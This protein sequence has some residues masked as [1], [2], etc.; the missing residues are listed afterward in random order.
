MMKFLFKNFLEEG[1]IPLEDIR[2]EATLKI[3]VL[4]RAVLPLKIFSIRIIMA[5]D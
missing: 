4:T 2:A 5:R 1:V 3:R